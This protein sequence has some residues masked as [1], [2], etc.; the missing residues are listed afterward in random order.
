[1][2]DLLHQAH[3]DLFRRP[4]E[5]HFE[6]FVALRTDAAD[7]RR[8]CREVEARNTAVLFGA[9]GDVYFGEHAVQPT[10]F[11]L[12]QLAAAAKVPMPVLARLDVGTRASVL[13]QTFERNRR[14]RIGLADGD[15]LRAVTSDRYERVWDEELYDAIDRWLLPS[16]FVPAV[17]TM[18]TDVAHTNAMGN[19]KPALFRSDRDSFAF[20]YSEKDPTD[21]F[22]GLRKG[23]VVFN[24]EVGAKCLGYA[25]F[26]FRDMCSN[27]LIWGAT[28]FCERT[29]RHTSQ[30]RETFKAFDAE[31]RSIS[32]EVS[33]T[34][35]SVID[36]AAK[37]LF[38]AGNDK[39]AAEERLIKQFKVSPKIAPDVVDAVFLP[40]NPSELTHWGVVNGLTSV[41][42]ALPYADDRVELSRF[43]GQLL[44]TA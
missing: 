16:G 13:N 42:K 32:N 44:A 39:K 3:A 5:Q 18:N 7:Q 27:F 15:S 34:E 9:E 29:A 41:A 1:M 14:F 17:P 8:R 12:T 30:V 6:S 2:T 26:L 10:H 25:T 37:T 20:F 38:V 28:G 19:T 23:V 40:E 33:S 11:S 43:A 22:G 21:A 35:Y 4:P 36:R 24:S 31:L